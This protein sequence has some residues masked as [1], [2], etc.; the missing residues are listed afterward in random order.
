M[1]FPPGELCEVSGVAPF[2]DNLYTETT[3]WTDT[4]LTGGKLQPL[5]QQR[6]SQKDP[7]AIRVPSHEMEK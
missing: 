7:V 2:G 5:L 4:G 1:I 3:R 6:L